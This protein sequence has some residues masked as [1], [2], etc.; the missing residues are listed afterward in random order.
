MNVSSGSSDFVRSRLCLHGIYLILFGAFALR[1]LVMVDGLE[2]PI[3]RDEAQYDAYAREMQSNILEYDEVYR[4]PVYPGFVALAYQLGGGGR[5]SVSYLQALLDSVNL[6]LVFALTHAIFH[7]RSISMLAAGLYAVYPEAI[8]LTRQFYSETVFNLWILGTFYLLVRFARTRARAL[9][10]P[11][12]IGLG[13]ACITRELALFF[14]LIVVPVWLVVSVGAPDRT[15]FAQVGLFLVGL[16][17]VLAP[18]GV[19]NWALEGRFIPVATESE[20]NLLQDNLKTQ[21]RIECGTRNNR[22]GA[23]VIRCIPY[24]EMRKEMLNNAPKGEQMR[25]AMQGALQVISKYPFA[26]LNAKLELLLV[27]WMPPTAKLHYFR[28]QGISGLARDAFNWVVGSYHVL[29]LLWAVVGVIAA[30]NDAPKL[31]ILLYLLYMLSIFMVTHF[32]ARYREP[33][34]VAFMPYSA[35]GLTVVG[36]LL[37][38]RVAV[39]NWFK[40][41]RTCA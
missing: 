30:R 31:L 20:K 34:F 14:A 21:A 25:V 26:W 22:P 28:V 11:A 9:M 41:L 3:V 40:M 24:A 8:A 29:F 27:R 7:R 38:N 6:V 19:R 32:Q 36:M 5:F 23:A 16:V 17:I 13:L 2:L 4:P 18:W 1:I 37:R 15:A 39:R 35:Y 12:G 10:L 33:L